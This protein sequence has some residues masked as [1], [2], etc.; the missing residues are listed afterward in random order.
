M[1]AARP[2]STRPECGVSRRCD[3]SARTAPNASSGQPSIAARRPSSTMPRTDWIQVMR[4][5]PAQA[6]PNAAFGGINNGATDGKPDAV[7][8]R[9]GRLQRVANVVEAGRAQSF[10]GHSIPEPA[11]ILCAVQVRFQSTDSDFVNSAWD[12]ADPNKY[13]GPNGVDRTNQFSF[14]G[15]M[16][17]PA[18]FQA[19]VIGHFYSAL[20]TTL[21]LAPT[22]TPGGMFVTAA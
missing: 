15:T 6:C 5:V 9:A 21:T 14:G 16:E 4:S 7:S 17:L 8:H 1:A 22:G 2:Q 18:H 13:I 19:S 20:P 3:G 11:S 12:Y 10:Q